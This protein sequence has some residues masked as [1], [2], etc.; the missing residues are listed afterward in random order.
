DA[1]PL[2][3]PG[4]RERVPAL[5]QR[6]AQ[7]RPDRLGRELG[8]LQAHHVGA[9]LV[10]PR[11][12]PGQALLD[13]VDVPGRDPHATT[14]TTGADALSRAGWSACRSAAPGRRASRAPA[15]PSP[16]GRCP[17]PRAAW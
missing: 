9:A 7:Q 2:R 1:V 14:V 17:R 10:E 3:L 12:Q 11:Q 15:T 13:R 6:V 8:L 4:C 5:A 16:G